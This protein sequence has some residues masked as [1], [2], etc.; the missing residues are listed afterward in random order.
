MSAAAGAG[1]P[2]RVSVVGAGILGLATA[3]YLRREGVDVSVFEGGAI[4]SGASWG[5]AGE[6]CPSSSVPLPSRGVVREGIGQL[7]RSD[8][9]FYVHPTQALRMAPFLLGFALRSKERAYRAGLAALDLLNEQTEAC[10]QDMAADGIGRSMR[11]EGYVYCFRDEESARESRGRAIELA[12]RGLGPEPGPL[13]SGADLRHLEPAI[14]LEGGWGYLQEGVLWVDPRE[15]LSDL[16]TWLRANDVAIHE[17]S[18][19]RGIRTRPG[20][21]TLQFNGGSQT[22]DAV[23]LAAGARSGELADSIGV[24]LRLKPGKGYSFSVKPE[25]MPG[26]VIVMSQVH[27]VATPM[28]T[29]L[30]IAGTMEFDGTYDRMNP[31]RIKAIVKGSQDYLAGID[32]GDLREEWV[33]ARPMTPDGLP[34]IG[35]LANAPSV[36]VATGHNMLGLSLGPASAKATAGLIVGKLRA[37]EY[38]VFSPN[39][40]SAKGRTL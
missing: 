18:R 40:F 16:A 21:A 8:S 11:N 31:G 17:G 34:H 4:G 7:F 28:A 13:L 23:V 29:G 3:Y 33:G 22:S 1:N 19:V 20:G 2:L 39:R 24:K 37:E 14:S 35:A 9:A 36:F 32:W 5:N 38:E 15:L 25:V 6:I 12:K 27:S 26:H 10:L 30:R